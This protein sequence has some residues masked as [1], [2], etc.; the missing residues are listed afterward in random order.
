MVL[1]LADNAE[2]ISEDHLGG[3]GS[4]GRTYALVGTPSAP[5]ALTPPHAAR[6]GLR[7]VNRAVELFSGA[8]DKCSAVGL[9]TEVV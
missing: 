2:L 8:G 1:L 9:R 6:M 3:T 7:P 4:A 5:N